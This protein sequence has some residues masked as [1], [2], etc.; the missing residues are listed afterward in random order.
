MLTIAVK[1][2]RRGPP[3]Q[4]AHAGLRQRVQTWFESRLVRTDTWLLIWW[5]VPLRPGVTAWANRADSRLPGPDSSEF[6][7]KAVTA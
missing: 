1:A 5:L 4:D 3:G 6:T 2:A 7:S